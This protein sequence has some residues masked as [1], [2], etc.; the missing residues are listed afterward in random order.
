MRGK[1][2]LLYYLSAKSLG[3]EAFDLI[4]A[5][6]IVENRFSVIDIRYLCRFGIPASRMMTK[7][8][9]E[10]WVLETG[11]EYTWRVKNSKMYKSKRYLDKM[12]LL[13]RKRIY[14]GVLIK[15]K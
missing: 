11:I 8:D 12:L 4:N 2:S 13:I 14:R 1:R 7:G 3:I 6:V 15:L 5:F 10:K 9:L